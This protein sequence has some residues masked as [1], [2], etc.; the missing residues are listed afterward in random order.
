MTEGRSAGLRASA[1]IALPTVGIG[2]SFGVLAEP[3]IGGL[4]AVVMSVLVWAGAAQFAAVTALAGGAAPGV[5]ATTGLLANTR[6]LPMGFAIAP[7]LPG[8]VWQRAGTGALLADASFAVAHRTGADFD[9]PALRWAFPLQYASWVGGTILG[10][11]GASAIDPNVLGLDVLFGVF[12]LSLLLPEVRSRLAG[13][14]ALLAAGLTLALTP[15][16]PEGIPVLLAASVA[17][18]GLR[19]TTGASS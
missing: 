3:V 12:Y 5:A 6:Y 2:V 14:A 18:L 15:I 19:N 1:A 8:P 17:L 9:I 16:L 11:A 10:V 4:A 7:S 13:S